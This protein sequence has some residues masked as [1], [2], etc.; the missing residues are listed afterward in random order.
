MNHGF[1]SLTLHPS[2][3]EDIFELRATKINSQVTMAQDPWIHRAQGQPGESP[4]FFQHLENW[5]DPFSVRREREGG[6]LWK[7][8]GY[9]LNRHR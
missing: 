4:E 5:K 2:A 7:T 6:V 8:M 3:G 1:Y 9:F